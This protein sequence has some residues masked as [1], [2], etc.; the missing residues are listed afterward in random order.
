VTSTF[1]IPTPGQEQAPDNPDPVDGS[2]WA[3]DISLNDVDY[4]EEIQKDI[5]KKLMVN[6]ACDPVTGVIVPR[7]DKELVI[8]FTTNIPDWLGIQA[9][10]GTEGRGC[11]N[12]ELLT[13]TIN[14]VERMFRAG[15][16]KW[17]GST[18]SAT[19]D[20][21]GIVYPRFTYRLRER[22]AAPWDSSGN[23]IMGDDGYPDWS[24]SWWVRRGNLGLNNADVNLSDGTRKYWPIV[25]ASGNHI[26]TA[27]PLATT[28]PT[29]LSGLIKQV[30]PAA[31]DTIL[32]MLEF[33]VYEKL[34]FTET[35]LWDLN[36]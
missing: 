33:E 2:R 26:T 6:T 14:G 10:D 17:F 22:H 27:V 25:D 5:H 12:S 13:L 8:S 18:F 20:A 30:R 9:A 3:I 29:S 35:L 15:T 1:R 23:P 34:N 31:P 19:L 32:E 36:N 28:Y 4:E 21:S 24:K 7:R 16:L 11:V